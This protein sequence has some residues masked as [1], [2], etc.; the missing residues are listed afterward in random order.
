MY[1]DHIQYHFYKPVN[2]SAD[3]EIDTLAVRFACDSTEDKHNCG[4]GGSIPVII[5]T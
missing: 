1:N 4:F 3:Y 5:L 2:L